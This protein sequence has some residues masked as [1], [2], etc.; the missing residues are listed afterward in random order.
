MVLQIPSSEL[1]IINFRIYRVGLNSCNLNERS[2]PMNPLPIAR[3]FLL[4][5]IKEQQHEISQWNTELWPVC[6]ND[7]MVKGSLNL[8]RM[9]AEWDENCLS[10][11]LAV[12]AS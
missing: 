5:P 12:S 1:G 11:L 9:K 3:C 8:K 2:I 4:S 6:Q 7:K 10:K